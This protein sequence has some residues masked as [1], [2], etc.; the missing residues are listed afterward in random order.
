MGFFD[1]FKSNNDIK[2]DNSEK[3]L[4]DVLLNGTDENTEIDVTRNNVMEIPSVASGV[5]VI[6]SLIAS[7]PIKLYEVNNGNVIE[8]TEDNRLRLLNLQSEKAMS[9]YQMKEELIKDYLLE[10][11]GFIYI[12]KPEY[13]NKI[14][15]LHYV[16]ESDVSFLSNYNPIFKDVKIMINGKDYEAY[17]FIILTQNSNNGV[18]GKGI[19]QN[20]RELLSTMLTSLKR[21]KNLA[22]TGGVN[23]GILKSAK[24][25]SQESMETLKKA[26]KNLYNGN[27]NAMVLNDGLDFVTVSQT[28]K[29]MELYNNK[30]A[31]NK[32]INQIL[33]IP[34]SII[35]GTATD[36]EFNNWVKISIN[37][38]LSQLEIA[39]N[40]SLL[41]S[42][43]VGKKFFCVD[44]D[45]ILKS[46][47]EKRYKAYE[48]ALKAGFLT[49]DEVRKY[50][51]LEEIPNIGKL[52][53][54]TQGEVLY[55]PEANEIFNTNSSTKT[56]LDDE[57]G[58]ILNETT[59]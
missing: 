23:R 7:L 27:N 59:I 38:I 34:N 24:K 11:N 32:L 44:T 22:K 13:K 9:A 19:I 58:N 26:W 20:N 36:A 47:I 43:E 3:E 28:S 29:D 33:N 16:K 12:N 6:S 49:L 51:N 37:P 15:S 50:E 48:T 14:E 46:D 41:F 10:G 30:Q 57:G 53:R 56:Q 52:V 18:Q 2:I 17:N 39:L 42:S 21:E 40:N 31:N 5:S 55:N 54:M 45:E 25:I 35:E 8:I 4:R 1:N